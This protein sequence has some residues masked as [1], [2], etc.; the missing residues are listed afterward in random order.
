ML[1][2]SV[3]PYK[4]N[5]Q[6]SLNYV[7]KAASFGFKRVFTNILEIENQDKEDLLSSM[8]EVIQ[9]ARRQSMEVMLDVNPTVFEQLNISYHNLS[10][11]KKM[12]ATAIRLDS[13]F[14]GFVE[15]LMTFDNNNLDIEINIS[16]D[17]AYLENVLSYAPQKKKIIGCHNFYPQRFTGLDDSY[18]KKC[19]E[20]YKSMGLRTAA[21]IN[22]HYGDH[23]P[24]PFCD[25]LCTLEMHRDMKIVTQAKHLIAIGSIDDIIIANAFASDQELEA[26][27]LVNQN[28]IV[29][30]VVFNP[31]VSEE[32]KKLVLDNQHFNR[33]DISS[34]MIRSTYVKTQYKNTSIPV[35][36]TSDSLYYGDITIGNDTFGQYRG[37]LNIVTK[38]MSDPKHNKNV[39]GKVADDEQFLISY[40]KPWTK[41]RF[42]ERKKE[43]D[44]T[45]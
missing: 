40:I 24:H 10:F 20:K 14:D 32:E 30:D 26:I 37:E 33:G 11:F 25:G 19:S 7:K 15:S 6:D 4:E 13:S 34:Y 3:Y 45:L 12:G 21:F 35:N 1:G 39:V 16:N 22:S 44:I 42:I 18:F 17:T 31:N 5:I 43:D 9:Y 27:S 23:G 8:K 29:L 28:Q 2:I 36:C 38:E 41:F